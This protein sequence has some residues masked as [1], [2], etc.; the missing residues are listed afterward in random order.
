[1]VLAELGSKITAALR[2]M[3]MSTVIDEKVLDEMLKEIVAALLSADVNVL[4][5][6]QLRNNIKKRIN[7]DEMA[8]GMNRRR[9]IQQAVY[10]ELCSLIDPGIKPFKTKKR[11]T[12]RHYVRRFTRKW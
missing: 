11:T 2:T 9:I 3:T 5:V 1:M 4:L 12:Q 6:S 7:L 8:S 10:E